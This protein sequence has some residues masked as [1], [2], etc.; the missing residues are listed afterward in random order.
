MFENIRAFFLDKLDTIKALPARIKDSDFWQGDSSKPVIFIIIV[1]ALVSLLFG[2]VAAGCLVHPRTRYVGS[3]IST[4]RRT[5]T[6]LQNAQ[7]AAQSATTTTTTSASNQVNGFDLSTYEITINQVLSN[8]SLPTVKFPID[9]LPG[10]VNLSTIT[11][12]LTAPKTPKPQCTLFSVNS[13]SNQNHFCTWPMAIDKYSQE[14]RAF[15]IVKSMSYVP[16]DTFSP[17]SQD[18]A[19]TLTPNAQFNI[20][21]MQDWAI[22]TGGFS[23]P[24][25]Y[26]NFP[27]AYWAIYA[28]ARTCTISNCYVT[29]L[30]FTA[31]PDLKYQPFYNNSYVIFLLAVIVGYNFNNDINLI[32]IQPIDA[33]DWNS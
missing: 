12:P 26:S 16:P 18:V 2:S 5:T 8:N 3:K 17:W 27:W 20:V 25:D 10:S 22:D 11:L 33:Y 13:N 32:E 15:E 24:Q 7:Q 4:I 21:G 6:T 31:I 19:L 14:Y 23:V 28:G 1:F 29:L 30:T 9:Y